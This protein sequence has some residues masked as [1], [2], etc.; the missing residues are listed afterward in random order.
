MGE[1]WQELSQVNRGFYCAAAFCSVFFLW[2]LISALIGLGGHD[3]DVDHDVDPGAGGADG[4]MDHTYDT[5]EHGAESDAI[6]TVAA[7]KLLSVRSIITFLTLFSWGG[8]LYLNNGNE[9]GYAMVLSTIWGFAGMGSV[10]GILY[11]LPKLTH[12]GTQKIASCVG[13]QGEVYLDIP[14]GG[15]GE[16]R[17][18]VSGVVSTIKART[19]AGQT[20]TAGTAVKVTRLLDV[21][22]VEVTPLQD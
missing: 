14:D 20:L 19:V 1:W 8:A 4:G 9:M 17:V 22:T 2:Q 6:E 16:V 13:A 3:I 10:A 12:T 18:L 7:F 15:T 21:V 11:L 5:F